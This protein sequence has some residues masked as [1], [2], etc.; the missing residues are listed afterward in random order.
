LTY[1]FRPPPKTPVVSRA[2]IPPKLVRHY[3][4]KFQV[5]RGLEPTVRFLFEEMIRQG[6]PTR[7]MAERC[8]VHPDTIGEWNRGTNQPKIGNLVAALNVIGFTLTPTRV[9]APE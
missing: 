2:L 9:E 4:P 3:P 5:R 1:V 8:G 6:M 7:V